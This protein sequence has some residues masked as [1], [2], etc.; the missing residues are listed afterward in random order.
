M[1]SGAPRDPVRTLA[2]ERGQA[3]VEFGVMLMMFMTLILGAL[4]FGRAWN[5]SS[6]VTQASREGARVAAV[7]CTLNASCSTSVTTSVQNAL[8]GLDLHAA[9]WSVT[10]GPYVSGSPVTVNVTYT[11]TPASPFVAALLPGG[12]FA[13]AGS[14]TMR[15]E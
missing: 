5:A 14:T 3:V 6:I 11:V 2:D 10:A 4:E 1:T 7:S 12:V 8:T 9:H 13:I 15:L